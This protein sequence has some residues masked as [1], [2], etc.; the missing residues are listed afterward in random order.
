MWACALAL[1]L[2]L[3]CGEPATVLA[4]EPPSSAGPPRT[5][6]VALDG[7]GQFQSIQEAIDQSSDGDTI[8]IKAGAYSEDVTV[9]SKE[10][11]RLIGDGVDQVTIL[12]LRR[13]GSF[14][15]GKWPYGA[16]DIEI[17]GLTIH[18]HGGLALGI[19]NG[20][21]ITLRNVRI[22]GQ[23]FGQ[24][25]QGVQIENSVIGGSETTGVSF[26]DSQAVL[27]RNLIHDNDHGVKVAGKSHVRLDH[28]VITRS[29][30]EGVVVTDEAQAVLVSNTIVKNGGGVAFLGHSRS[31]VSGNIVGLNKV[32]FVIGPSSRALTSYNALY[33]S[34]GN[35][36]KTGPPP[37]PAPDLKADSD[38]ILDPRFVDP[39]LYDFRLRTDTPLTRI[40][41]FA[42]LGALPPIDGSP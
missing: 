31:E 18:E 40:G 28:N 11:L 32:G 5:V 13:V 19:F 22:K 9:H 29:L 21:A 20:R 35:F 2:A 6:V 26:V 39:G 30:F 15:I 16:T 27:V 38:L 10:G 8:R 41:G 12:G 37:L 36:L 23:L 3:S 7:S 24:E 4:G 33:N 42:F 34:E 1:A 14:H 25:V 17:S